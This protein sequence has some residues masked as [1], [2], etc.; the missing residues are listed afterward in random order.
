MEERETG[1][2]LSSPV[3]LAKVDERRETMR[4]NEQNDQKAKLEGSVRFCRYLSG[5]DT[6]VVFCYYSSEVLKF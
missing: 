1:L 3:L 4:I 6:A 2:D 5:L